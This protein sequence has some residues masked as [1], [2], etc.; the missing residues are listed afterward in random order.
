M[1]LKKYLEF[2]K[3]VKKNIMRNWSLKKQLLIA[4]LVFLFMGILNLIQSI[5]EKVSKDFVFFG[6]F[7]VFLSLSNVMSK[8]DMKKHY[9]TMIALFFLV[10]YVLLLIFGVLEL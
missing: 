9:R 2:H 1:I 8:K 4:G 5:Q 10:I 7:L 6:I 3:I